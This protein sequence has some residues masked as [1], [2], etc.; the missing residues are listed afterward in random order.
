[1]ILT[2]RWTDPW[3][4]T[5]LELVVVI[6]CDS[7]A[8]LK[9]SDNNNDGE[10]ESTLVSRS[11]T[12][13]VIAVSASW[14]NVPVWPGQSRFRA[15]YPGV[16][17]G[18][19]RDTVRSRFAES[20]TGGDRERH[21]WLFSFQYFINAIVSQCLKCLKCVRDNVHALRVKAERRPV[22]YL[23]SFRWAFMHYF[24]YTLSS[25]VSASH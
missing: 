10:P 8:A 3:S 13:Y 4:Q 14:P 24:F 18:Y 2:K 22:T 23:S 19:V 15:R 21:L 6:V 20:R 9:S 5:G 7:K 12:T 11:L 17:K 16:P 1:M 25:V